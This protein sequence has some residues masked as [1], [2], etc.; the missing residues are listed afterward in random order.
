LLEEAKFC[1]GFEV[2]YLSKYL[3]DRFNCVFTLT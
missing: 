1:P 3:L 2:R